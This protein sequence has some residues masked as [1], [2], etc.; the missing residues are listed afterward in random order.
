VDDAVRALYEG[1]KVELNQ[2]RE[3]ATLLDR[4][5]EVSKKMIEMGAEAKNFDLC[6]GRRDRRQPS[7]AIASPLCV[8]AASSARL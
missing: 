4:L 8:T 6:N 5:A 2:P 1:K 7:P 3:V